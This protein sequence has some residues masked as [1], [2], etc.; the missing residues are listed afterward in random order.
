MFW[1][2]I[3]GARTGDQIVEAGLGSFVVKP[4]NIALTF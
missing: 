4:R 2:D 1:K 3:L